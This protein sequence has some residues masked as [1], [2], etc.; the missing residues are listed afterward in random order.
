[1]LW[2]GHCITWRRNPACLALWLLLFANHTSHTTEQ[3]D[4]EASTWYTAAQVA[5]KGSSKGGKASI[6]Q[7][8]NLHGAVQQAGIQKLLPE[9]GQCFWLQHL[10]T[11]PLVM[12]CSLFAGECRLLSGHWQAL[13]SSVHCNATGICRS[14]TQ[15]TPNQTEE[16][17]GAIAAKHSTRHYCLDCR[18]AATLAHG[19]FCC[20]CALIHP[21][22]TDVPLSQQSLPQETALSLML[23]KIISAQFH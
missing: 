20:L 18:E 21:W 13:E 2:A 10:H 4:A 12:L 17:E 11:H 5:A 6:K 7:S 1:M 22:G 8:H 15:K 23:S 14:R 9:E 16:H 19:C 3:C